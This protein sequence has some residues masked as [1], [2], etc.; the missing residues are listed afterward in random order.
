MQ[1]LDGDGVGNV[2]GS[3]VVGMVV[4]K[5]IGAAEGEAVE[6]LGAPVGWL[7]VVGC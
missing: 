1:R 3:A 2:D 5:Y 4:G 7:L 6:A